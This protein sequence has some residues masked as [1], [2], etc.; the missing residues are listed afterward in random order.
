ML[1]FEM[2]PP[3]SFETFLKKCLEFIPSK[4]YRI[5]AELPKTEES[6][7]KKITQPII[8]D[9]IAFDAALRNELVKVR[10]SRKHIEPAKYL[11][12]DGY[13]GQAISHIALSAHRNTSIL[14]A[15]RF[16][17]RERWNFLEEQAVGHYFDLGFLI[18]YAYKL[19]I[20][21]RWE[22]INTADKVMA[23]EETLRYGG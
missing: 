13:S 15:E 11:R 14:D 18:V 17:D 16:L 19:L 6:L 9:W 2:R 1:H 12:P 5:L 20:L 21:E 4:D 3:F 8:K 22:R 10:A 23:L 7:G